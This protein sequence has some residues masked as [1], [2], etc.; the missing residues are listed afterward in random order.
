[1]GESSHLTRAN[2]IFVWFKRHKNI[3][4]DHWSV[5]DLKRMI[6]TNMLTIAEPHV[7]EIMLGY[8]LPKMWNTYD[9]YH[10]LED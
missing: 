4:M 3:E 10:Y 8:I 1:M 6:R 9:K 7:C 2:N 5:H